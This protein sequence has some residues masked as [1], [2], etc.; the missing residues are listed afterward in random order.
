MAVGLAIGG[1]AGRRDKGSGRLIRMAERDH[2]ED[3]WTQGRRN[4][5]ELP[6]VPR[7]A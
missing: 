1:A 7:V 5:L 2:R 6:T 3:A 4:I